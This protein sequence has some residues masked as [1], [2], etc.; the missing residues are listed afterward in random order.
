MVSKEN[1]EVLVQLWECQHLCK[2]IK[3]KDNKNIKMKNVSTESM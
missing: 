3:K 1:T 2:G